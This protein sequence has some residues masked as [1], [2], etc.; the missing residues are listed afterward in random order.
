MD[1]DPVLIVQAEQTKFYSRMFLVSPLEAGKE[2]R[3]GIVKLIIFCFS[4]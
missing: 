4:A 2:Q 3:G 1:R